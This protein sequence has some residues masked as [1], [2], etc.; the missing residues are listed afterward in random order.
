MFWALVFLFAF[1]GAGEID[2]DGDIMW[3]GSA[4]KCGGAG[5]WTEGSSAPIAVSTSCLEDG[6]VKNS[7]S[8]C[9]TPDPICVSWLY[10]CVI[11]VSYGSC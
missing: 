4:I 7:T 10:G 2:C 5:N 11:D 8:H 9:A 1:V 3:T 6:C